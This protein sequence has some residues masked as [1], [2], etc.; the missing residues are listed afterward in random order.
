MILLYQKDGLGILKRL[1]LDR[2][3]IPL[4]LAD[5]NKNLICKKCNAL[6]GIPMIYQKE[7]RLAYRLFSG[8][9]E[10]KIIKADELSEINF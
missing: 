3:I 7:K 6:L 10:K 4:S 5:G 8:A 2:I 1:Y 9:V